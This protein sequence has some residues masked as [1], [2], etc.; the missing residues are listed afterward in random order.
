MTRPT[1]NALLAAAALAAGC[2]ADPDRTIMIEPAPDPGPPDWPRGLRVV[3][4]HIEDGAGKTIVLHGVNRSGTEY[5]CVQDGNSMFDGPATDES[6][7]AIAAW[8][9]INTVRIPLN[10]SCW[11]GINGA[12][13]AQSGD[14]YK[15]AIR[16]YVLR[17]HKFDLIPILELHWVGP[18]T[19]RAERLQPMPDADHAL[20]L[21]ADVATTFL[22]DDGVI[23][24]PFNEPFPDGNK[25]TDAAW[26]CWRD[27]CQAN[28]HL[29]TTPPTST[30]QA[31]GMQAI[32]DTIRATGSTHVILLG[33]VQYSNALTQWLAHKP[34]DPLGQLG[35]AWHVYNFNG[36]K[37]ADCWDAAPAAVAAAV[38]VVATE[39]GEDT[40]MGGFITP[41]M[42]WLDG[43]SSG[44]LAWSWN[45]GT[46]CVPGMPPGRNNGRAWQLVTSYTLAA[47]NGGYAQTFRDHLAGLQP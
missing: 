6:I 26:A 14:F 2:A 42:Q 20:E 13:E 8:P 37:S 43:K 18:G 47:P 29:G 33:G 30:Y 19:T 11:L 45:S 34:N 9:N 15:A 44:Y 38:P 21:W 31:T 36:C 22:D 16:N 12:H 17:L 35:A 1:L 27:G 32:V 7:Q 25:D 5:K 4:N 39:I 41:L 10:E 28:L 23:L 46:M 3:G 40:C 24:E